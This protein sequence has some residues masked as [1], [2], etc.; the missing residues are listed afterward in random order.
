MV[1]QSQ[2]PTTGNLVV[3]TIKKPSSKNAE[4][5]SSL[6]AMFTENLFPFM[7]GICGLSTH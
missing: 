3:A 2:F 1:V 5:M 7:L 6:I 4:A